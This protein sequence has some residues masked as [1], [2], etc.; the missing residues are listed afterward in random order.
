MIIP[1]ISLKDEDLYITCSAKNIVNLL[2]YRLQINAPPFMSQDGVVS[3]CSTTSLFSII[4]CLEAKFNLNK[5][6]SHKITLIANKIDKRSRNFPSAGLSYQQ[7][8]NFFT[9][10]QLHPLYY[11]NMDSKTAKG[12]IYSYIENGI[13]ALA[14]LK[15]PQKTARHAVVIVGHSVSSTKTQR[16]LYVSDYIG[17]FI[18]HDDQRGPY[19]ILQFDESSNDCRIRLIFDGGSDEGIIESVIVPL[20]EFVNFDHTKVMEAL[21]FMNTYLKIYLSGRDIIFRVF[22]TTSNDFKS[23]VADDLGFAQYPLFQNA[24]LSY[25]MPRHIWLIEICDRRKYLEKGYKD[26]VIGELIIDATGFHTKEAILIARVEENFANG[27][28]N[29]RFVEIKK[30]PKIRS[31]FLPPREI[32][33]I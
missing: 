29:Q 32:Q 1:S 4:S 6:T 3:T 27:N 20:P 30:P 24:Y 26:C 16:G 25:R 12:V 7:M 28:L 19:T 13:P 22:L 2:G 18:V 14:N 17:H 9:E 23:Y 10:I 15:F 5:L 8:M 31:L 21:S 33:I 11:S